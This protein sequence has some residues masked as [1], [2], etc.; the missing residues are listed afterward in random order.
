M[1]SRQRNFFTGVISRLALGSLFVLLFCGSISGSAFAASASV[2]TYDDRLEYIGTSAE[3]NGVT[4]AQSGRTF[5][6]T[7]SGASIG[8]GTGCTSVSASTVT[9]TDVH[10]GYIGYLAVGT[11]GE[12]D[13]V[14]VNGGIAAYVDAGTGNDRV[15][16][17]AGKDWLMGGD[18]D[19]T[20]DGGLGADVLIGG[21]GT[22]TADFSA[23]TGSVAVTLDG[24][25]ND[26]Q[27]GEGDNV[28]GNSIESVTGGGA[29]DSLTGSAAA[30]A[31]MGGAGNDTL[32]GGAGGDT[33]DGGDG[34]DT[35]KSRDGVQD[36]VACGPGADSVDADAIDVVDAD[37][38]APTSSPTAPTE[39]L[40]DAVPS[41]VRM[42]RGGYVSL[43]LRCPRT[44]STRC[45]GTIVL[46]M[47]ARARSSAAMSASSRRT[48]ARKRFSIKPGT[49][50]KLKV[51]ISRNGRR[52][53]LRQ[54][55]VKCKASAVVRSGAGSTSSA[56]NVTLKAPK[57]G[58][59]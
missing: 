10:N 57:K 37:C 31:L 42:T 55:R 18:G 38:F 23:R 36:K 41:A 21:A 54:R 22:D 3:R 35:M 24:T 9:C 33:L 15:S 7:D 4:I 30:N 14:T 1:D 34:G 39:T 47:S 50:K 52:R 56:K 48:I 5:T 8:P 6:I 40:L 26:G 13:S 27:A 28:S 19:D 12:N 2:D 53:V 44:S 58:S 51:K 29:D 11:Y 17:G 45:S 16:T 59:S 46:R 20:L 43:R 49:T 25:A 32:D